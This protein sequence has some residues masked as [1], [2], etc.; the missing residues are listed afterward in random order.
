MNIDSVV[1]LF[2]GIANGTVK[3]PPSKSMSHRALICAGLSKGKSFINNVLLSDD[4]KATM[5]ALEHMG[6]KFEISDSTI[7]VTGTKKVKYDGNPINCNESGSTIRFLI[8]VFSLSNKKVTFTGKESLFKRPFKIYEEIFKAN[9]ADFEIRSNSI[10][11]NGRIKAR[12]YYINGNVSSQ[13][14][15]GLMFTLPLLKED[16]KVF[17]KGN[18]ESNSYIDLTIELLEHFGIDIQKIKNGYYIP[19]DQAYK[20]TDYDVEGD[21]S[22]SAFHLVAGIIGGHVQANNLSQE[23]NQG[24]KKIIRI[25]KRMKGRV[26]YTESGFITD[27]SKTIGTKIDISDCPDL[28]PIVALLGSVSTGTTILTNISRLRLKE[29]DRV[30]STV[31]TLSTLGADISVVNDEIV[32]HGKP[33]LKGGVTLDSYND[34]RIAMMIAIAAFVCE[35]EIALLRP[36]AINKSYPHFFEDYKKIGG[37]FVIKDW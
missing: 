31:N 27:K 23:S 24:D 10:V 33:Q 26:V 25:I 15:S 35:Q 8:P 2:P 9:E 13:F 37:K 4:I 32:I 6:A 14:F 34:H 17:Y 29:S 28:A 5:S 20:A 21:F 11:V 3:V 18:L 1:T 36:L 16:S 30:V 22:Q 19:G 7:I 12:D